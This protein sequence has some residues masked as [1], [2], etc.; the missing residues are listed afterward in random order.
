[1]LQDAAGRVAETFRAV[2][3]VHRKARCLMCGLEWSVNRDGKLRSHKCEPAKVK[4]AA[5]RAATRGAVMEIWNAA[6]DD[7]KPTL[8][9]IG[10]QLGVTRERVRQILRARGITMRQVREAENADRE[11]RQLRLRFIAACERALTR[12]PCK[13]CGAWVIRG[14]DATITCSHECAQR[15]VKERYILDPEYHERHRLIQAQT[16][17]RAPEKYK[18][19]HIE[20]AKRML[21]NNPPPPNRRY[22]TVHKDAFNA[23]YRTN[24]GDLMTETRTHYMIQS[25]GPDGEFM[26]VGSSVAYASKDEAVVAAKSFART[27]RHHVI[28]VT[29]EV[30]TVA[31]IIGGDLT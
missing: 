14:G 24:Q 11:L 30:E 16:Y 4:A 18:P 27:W 9:E 25:H 7:V 1:M 19:A 26:P 2:T 20:W 3:G 13:V 17:L 29:T 23:R 22:A 21:S 5:K 28:R 6:P 8:Q 15:W 31:V 12:P 10:D